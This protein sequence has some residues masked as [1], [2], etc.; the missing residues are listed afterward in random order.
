[1]TDVRNHAD[2]PRVRIQARRE[3]EHLKSSKVPLGHG[4]SYTLQ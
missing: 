3:A 4:A 2:L 1:M